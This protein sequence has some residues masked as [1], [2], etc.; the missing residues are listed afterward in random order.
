MRA[1]VLHDQES[2]GTKIKPIKYQNGKYVKKISFYL[3]L[4]WTFLFNQN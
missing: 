2:L 1:L 3:F 4:I